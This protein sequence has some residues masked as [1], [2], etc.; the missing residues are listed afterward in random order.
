MLTTW[1]DRC[2]T[3]EHA[4]H[5]LD[6]AV[7]SDILIKPIQKTIGEFSAHPPREPFDI[8]HVNES[9]WIL[10]GLEPD[11]IQKIKKTGSK[12][13]LT[14][15]ASCPQNNRNPWTTQFDG[16]V[17]FEPHTTD[18]FYYVP[19]GAPVFDSPEME[20]SNRIGTNGFPQERKNLLALAEACQELG[21]KLVAF[22]PES[23]HANA[24]DVANKIRERNPEALVRTDW[25][26][27]T[28]MLLGLSSCLAT[29]YPYLEWYQGAS[30]A[31][32]AGA[33]R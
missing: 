30:S 1:G 9:G 28:E 18:G 22:I 10:Q 11:S 4:R 21:L 16:V 2:G 3:S 26:S 31:A 33:A 6:H 24:Y 27:D 17:V 20:K 5:V 32:M 8:V 14:M 15:N 13:L 12:T 23:Q 29:C 19:I 7:A 25:V